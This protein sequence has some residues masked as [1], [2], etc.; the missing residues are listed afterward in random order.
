MLFSPLPLVCILV[1]VPVVAHALRNWWRLRT[2][3][4][5]H[6]CRRPPQ[7][8]R[9]QNLRQQ[10]AALTAHTWL[11]MWCQRYTTIGTT[12]ES[13]TVGTDSII[14]TIEPEN[15]KTILATSFSS[16]ALG[17]RRRNLL[18][19]LVGMGVFTA[20]GRAWEHSR[21]LIRPTFTKMRI[22]DLDLFE[23]HF[24][25]LLAALPPRSPYSGLIEVDLQ[26]LFFRMTLDSATEVLLGRSFHSLR[27]PPGSPFHRFM[28]AFDYAQLKVHTRDLLDRGWMKPLGLFRRLLRGGRKD[29]FDEACE[30]VNTVLD[31]TI[32]EFL[33]QL[34]AGGSSQEKTDQDHKQ[35]L[36]VLLEE[37]VQSTRDPL[38]LR[39]EL[40]NVLI[41]GRDTTASLL[42]NVFFMLARRPDL[43]TEVRTE[44][45]RVVG[46]RPP[47]Y[48]ALRDLKA[49][50]NVLFECLRLYPPVPFNSR[51]ATTD[52]VLPRGGGP[53]GQSPIL[54]RAGQAVNYHV[55]ALHRR[56][57]IFGPDAVVFRP[58]RWNDPSLR[59]GWGYIPFNGGPRIC[60]GQQFALTE[61]SYTVV[62]LIQQFIAIER[63]DVELEWKEHVALVTK[64]RRGTRVALVLPEK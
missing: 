14:F 11:D 22:A 8:S 23:S 28:E 45:L 41:A 26:P 48:E 31:E 33:G 60:L 52:T 10:M 51:C 64:S 17:E 29:R 24:Q 20:D 58:S 6:G 50:R 55:Y 46:Q 3:A 49:V 21:S 2:L 47:T 34:H 43:W 13:A 18:S 61:A 37:M 5:E 39:Y 19:P 42:S 53:D 59:P 38:E 1:V 54:V 44:V 25:D 4:T 63:R 27:A 35:K 15:I 32:R 12:F 57:D 9:L 62:R 30:T 36:Y 7:L 40:L 56:P 16:F